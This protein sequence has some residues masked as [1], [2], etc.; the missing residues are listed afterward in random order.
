MINPAYMTRQ[1]SEVILD[2]TGVR[3]HITSLKPINPKN[4]ALPW[5]A[6]ALR[7]FERGLEEHFEVAIS[8]DVAR[9]QFI[10]PL[11]TK[12]A[13]LKCHEKQGYRVGD[14]RGGISVSF[15]AHPFLD[16][17]H[18]RKLQMVWGHLMA[19]VLFSGLSLAGLSV[20]LRQFRQLRV[21]KEGLDI[22][23]A[24]RTAELQSEVH[25][26][27]GAESFLRMLVNAS[28]EAMFGID[29]AG[30]CNF[31][32]PAALDLLGYAQAGD[33]IGMNLLALVQTRNST[34]DKDSYAA[35]RAIET[36]EIVHETESWFTRAD[37]S[38]FPVEYRSHPI[39]SDAGIAGAVI[40]FDDISRRKAE[41]EQIWHRANHDPLTGLPNRD[42]LE[43]RM[44]NALS[45]A[46]RHGGQAGVMFIDLDKFKEANDRFGHAAG[47]HILRETAQRMRACLR[48][49]DTVARLGGDEFVI[50]MPMP[51]QRGDI[52]KAAQR[53]VARIIEPYPLAQGS[54]EISASVGIALF[55]EHGE[56]A[57]EILRH[58][59]IAMYRAKDAGRN[60]WR[61]FG[62]EA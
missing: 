2:Q 62:A 36:G 12:Q 16:A 29:K 49:T 25:E 33:V 61:M 51:I 5:E 60:T 17:M 43:D 27:K 8:G 20:I 4:Q 42:L 18:T 19:W 23:V 44:E 30:H 59:D 38:E 21:A 22:L 45:L 34:G 1:M 10:R 3:I 39:F 15:D 47:D 35:C 52:E 14:I 7:Q 6:H 50:L 57:H 56:N 41:Q 32:N 13:C 46:R 26:R 11:V 24:Q 54:A 48:D 55:P 40:T 31:I 28:G 53:I 58:A 37:G 9:A